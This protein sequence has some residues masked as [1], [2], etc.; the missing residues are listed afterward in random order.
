MRSLVLALTAFAALALASAVGCSSASNP[1]P[2]ASA[3]GGDDAGNGDSGSTN[4]NLATVHFQTQATVPAGG[5]IFDCQ[6]VQLPNVEE[7]LVAAQHDYTPGSHHILLYTTALTTIPTGGGQV[8][9]CYEGTGN[10]I[11]S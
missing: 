4:P 11:M 8:Q 6:Y 7:W 3:S 1:S 10:N 2:P 5:E 9:D